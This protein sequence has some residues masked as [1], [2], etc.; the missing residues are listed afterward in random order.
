MQSKFLAYV[1][2]AFSQAFY[3]QAAESQVLLTYCAGNGPEAVRG[4]LI[5]RILSRLPFSIEMTDTRSFFLSYSIAQT[6]RRAPVQSLRKKTSAPYSSWTFSHGRRLI[7]C[8]GASPMTYHTH[9]V[10]RNLEPM[11]PQGKRL[12]SAFRP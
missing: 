4:A 9:G 5:V 11:S 2:M 3:A 12:N 8:G 1:A 7:Q 10:S 6:V